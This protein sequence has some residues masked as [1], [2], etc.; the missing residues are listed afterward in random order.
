MNTCTICGNQHDKNHSYCNP[1][2][3]ANQ[4]RRRR[5]RSPKKFVSKYPQ[6]KKQLK[7]DDYGIFY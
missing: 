2:K 4:R 7:V 1:C 3:N 6:P 5:E